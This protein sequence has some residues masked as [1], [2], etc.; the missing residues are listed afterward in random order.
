MYAQ[1][2]HSDILTGLV[3]YLVLLIT[4]VGTIA[5]CVWAYSMAGWVGVGA[6]WLTM[7]APVSL[8]AGKMFAACNGSND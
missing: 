5:L 2:A 8:I 1:N 3:L 4:I 7:S 6:T